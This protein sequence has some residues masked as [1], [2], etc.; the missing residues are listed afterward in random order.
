MKS[1]VKYARD[2]TCSIPAAGIFFRIMKKY[3][4]TQKLVTMTANEFT[5]NLKAVLGKKES[6]GD[7]SMEDVLLALWDNGLT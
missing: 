4:V 2:S 6:R 3:S 1:E 7:V 5:E